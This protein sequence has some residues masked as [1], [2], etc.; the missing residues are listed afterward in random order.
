MTLTQ[1]SFADVWSFVFDF[2]P[3][4]FARTRSRRDKFGITHRGSDEMRMTNEM[5]GPAYAGQAAGRQY[6]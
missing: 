4:N 3:V 6:F 5:G 2:L 1:S